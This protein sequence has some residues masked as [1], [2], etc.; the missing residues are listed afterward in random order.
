[1]RSGKCRGARV[2]A[3]FRGEGRIAKMNP[4]TTRSKRVVGDVPQSRF[5]DVVKRPSA[6]VLVGETG[7]YRLPWRCSLGADGVS[8]RQSPTA[9]N[10]NDALSDCVVKLLEA[11]GLYQKLTQATGRAKLW[12]WRCAAA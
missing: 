11:D 1:M 12:V 8:N 5:I 4:I 7:S 9:N 6:A 10:L 2:F 3:E